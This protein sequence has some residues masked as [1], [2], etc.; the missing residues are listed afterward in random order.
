MKIFSENK[1]NK[2]PVRRQR[3]GQP[4]SSGSGQFSRNRTLTG[5][6]SSRVR[7]ANE[8]N[9]TIKSPRAKVHSLT[10]RRR[11]LSTLLTVVVICIVALLTILM[12]LTV[13]PVISSDD[14]L[15]TKQKQPYIESIQ[16]YYASRPVER[17]NFL[18][19]EDQFISY[20]QAKHPEVSSVE[21]ISSAGFVHTNFTLDMRQPV[22]SWTIAGRTEY[23]DGAGMAFQ[24]N[25]FKQPKVEIVDKSGVELGDSVAVA[26]DQFLGFVGQVI[27]YSKMFKLPVKQVVLPVGTTR[28]IEVELSGSKVLIKMSI[29]RSAYDQVE[30]AARA[31]E[32]LSGRDKT[33]VYIDVRIERKAYYLP[34]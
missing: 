16:Q 33:P 1:T 14:D 25:Y 9:S 7:S 12:Q 23:V 31:V 4:S 30:D 11:K 26:S 32:Y 19:N 24:Q 29:D 13:E 20:L 10:K 8:L 6:S 22:A 27:G 3:A 28:Q 21:D 17:L 5:S 34:K 2:Q 18:L 15:T